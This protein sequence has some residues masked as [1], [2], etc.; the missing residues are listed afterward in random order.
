LIEE[1]DENN[2][3]FNFESSAETRI[4]DEGEVNYLATKYSFHVPL[5]NN[6]FEAGE[7]HNKLAFKFLYEKFLEVEPLNRKFSPLDNVIK[8]S[9]LIID[10]FLNDIIDIK[11]NEELKR[12][13]FFYESNENSYPSSIRDASLS[14][15]TGRIVGFSN[16]Q[17]KPEYNIY[18]TKDGQYLILRIKLNDIQLNEILFKPKSR[19]S[20]ILRF[21]IKVNDKK[22]MDLD[23]NNLIIENIEYKE[24]KNFDFEI[25]IDKEYDISRKENIKI[26]MKEGILTM[27][28]PSYPEDEHNDDEIEN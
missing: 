8:K 25:E 3:K 11:Y 27:L 24:I 1:E 19:G 16:I 5:M 9:K 28:I 23:Q 21:R 14:L 22:I 13:E 7:K 4:Y 10:S 20:N 6:N 2:P 18:K 12:I 17:A 26:E 15:L